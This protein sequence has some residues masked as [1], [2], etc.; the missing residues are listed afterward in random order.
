MK[1]A[2]GRIWRKIRSRLKKDSARFSALWRR[3]TLWSASYYTQWRC[4]S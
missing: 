2:T 4:K 3:N 1:N